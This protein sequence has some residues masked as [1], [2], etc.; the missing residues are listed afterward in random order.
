MYI[1]KIAEVV[2]G[3]VELVEKLPQAVSGGGFA[4]GYVCGWIRAGGKG[5][6]RDA[7]ARK[8]LRIFA[9]LSTSY[10]LYIHREG[11]IG[12]EIWN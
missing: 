2:V 6:P 8:P 3:G 7:Q 10:R 4:C 12:S 1:D 9:V 5:C 11:W